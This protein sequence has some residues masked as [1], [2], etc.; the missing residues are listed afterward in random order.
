[1]EDAVLLSRIAE[2]D[3]RALEELTDRFGGSMRA[4]AM[5]VTRSERVA[6]EVVQDSLMA[7]WRDPRR[8][9]PSRGTLGP[10]LLTLTRYKAIDAVRRETVIQRRTADVDL[11][12]REAPD[13][14]HN[15]VWLGIRRERL[16]AAIATLGPDQRR[17][18]EM[19][20]IG[21]LTH[22]EVAE[23][24]GIPLGTAKTRIRSA[25]LKL[26]DELGQSL[27]G[28]APPGATV[29]PGPVTGD[30]PV[31]TRRRTRRAAIGQSGTIP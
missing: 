18:L 20:F 1:V 4:V 31:P 11:S 5:R 16:Q 29:R 10:W 7:I 26:R 2:G 27:S 17:A 15:E 14:V 22:V 28:E 13:D 6:E 24:E 19:A 8:Y 12:L 23:R 3:E 30:F 25:L 9:E 21:G